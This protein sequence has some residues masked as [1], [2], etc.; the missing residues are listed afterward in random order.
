MSTNEK[1]MMELLECG[2]LD[3]FK[4]RLVDD[5]LNNEEEV[6]LAQSGNKEFIAAYITV[7]EICYEAEEIIRESGDEEL[8]DLI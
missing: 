1:T 8:I 7:Y 4:E 3:G 5:W 6:K 2:D